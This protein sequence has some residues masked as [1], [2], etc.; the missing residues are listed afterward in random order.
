MWS[1][2]MLTGIHQNW[3]CFVGSHLGEVRAWCNQRHC[4]HKKHIAKRLTQIGREMFH[5]QELG[6][7]EVKKEVIH[8]NWLM[9]IKYVVYFLNM[10]KDLKVMLAWEDNLSLKNDAW[11]I[12]SDQPDGIICMRVHI[13]S[14]NL[15]LLHLNY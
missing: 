13:L 4:S 11:M 12:H 1:M 14:P 15:R 2:I 5:L 9:V 8:T 7:R 10:C 3:S 6:Q